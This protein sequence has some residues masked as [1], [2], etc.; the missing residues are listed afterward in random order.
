[1]NAI[2]PLP[3]PDLSWIVD[4]IERNRESLRRSTML[5][6]Q[7]ENVGKRHSTAPEAGQKIASNP[8]TYKG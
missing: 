3:M 8:L 4:L 6:F 1:M 2:E 7:Q 5:E